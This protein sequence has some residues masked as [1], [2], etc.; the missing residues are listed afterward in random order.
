M[1]T[2]RAPCTHGMN[3]AKGCWWRLRLILRWKILADDY[4]AQKDKAWIQKVQSW[5]CFVK[6]WAIKFQGLD[7][8]RRANFPKTAAGVAAR[9][10]RFKAMLESLALC[11][12]FHIQSSR[13]D[14]LTFLTQSKTLRSPA[15]PYISPLRTTA[16]PSYV[17]TGV[18]NNG[19]RRGG[20]RNDSI[21]LQL[22]SAWRL[23]LNNGM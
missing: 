21:Y 16:F 3:S 12:G 17:D 7:K 9:A 1:P 6:H 8:M 2:S 22:K 19:H 23:S 4:Q 5:E 18:C 13:K 11:Q 15:L 20:V 10:W 14:V